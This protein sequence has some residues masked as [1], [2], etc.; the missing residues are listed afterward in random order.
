M[1]LSG[2]IVVKKSNR[3][4][5]R[6]SLRLTKTSPSLDFDEVAVKINIDVPDELFSKPKLEATIT[7][8]QEAVSSPTIDAE[9]IDNVEKIIKQNTGFEVRLNLVSVEEKE[10]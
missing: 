9:V 8:P 6:G 5:Y 4:P 10:E 2:F 3:Y 1:K 7:I